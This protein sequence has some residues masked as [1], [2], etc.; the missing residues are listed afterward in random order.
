M[1]SKQKEMNH[2]KRA[3]STLPPITLEMSDEKL[4]PLYDML[5]Q[6]W[7]LDWQQNHQFPDEDFPG[8]AEMVQRGGKRERLK[9]LTMKN[10]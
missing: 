6:C 5:E 1:D 2:V 8:F 10:Q 3:P 9:T 4:G 7:I